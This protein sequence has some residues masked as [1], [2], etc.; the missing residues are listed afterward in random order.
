MNPYIYYAAVVILAAVCIVAPIV[1][2]AIALRS[3]EA[4]MSDFCR[5]PTRA[6]ASHIESLLAKH[7][8]HRDELDATLYVRWLNIRLAMDRL[9]SFR[10][11]KAL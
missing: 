6:K 9:N 7:G 5:A 4:L 11:S 2:R 1:L 3:I 10:S 8:V